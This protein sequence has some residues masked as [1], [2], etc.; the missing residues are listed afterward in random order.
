MSWLQ[1]LRSS[2]LAR[3]QSA[4]SDVLE[5]LKVRLQLKDHLFQEVLSD[6][7]RQAQEHQEQVQD[8]LRTISSRDQYIQVEWWSPGKSLRTP[9]E[10]KIPML[11][12]QDSAARL[13][14]VMSEQTARLQELR[15]QLSSG[16]GARV[17][18]ES[19]LALEL[20]AMQE[21][22]RMALRREKENQE[23][24]RSQLDSLARTLQLKEELIGV[25]RREV[26]DRL[27]AVT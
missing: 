16:G 26:E 3:I 13:S 1:D 12:L 4:P 25:S 5:E 21:E 7:T 22:L 8:L 19:D 24:S 11:S 10:S 20:Q 27:L 14:E 17:D 6:R 15:R 18:S 23:V 9:S 2:L